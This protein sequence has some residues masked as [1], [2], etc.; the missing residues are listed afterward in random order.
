MKGL[1]RLILLQKK[2]KDK[3]KKGIKK[4]T[5]HTS[6]DILEARKGF[7]GSPL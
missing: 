6:V 7:S 2:N 1:R 3:N 5:K 4:I